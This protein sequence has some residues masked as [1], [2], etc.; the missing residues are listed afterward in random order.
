M[1]K[2][3]GLRTTNNESLRESAKAPVQTES[4]ATLL[5]SM[6]FPVGVGN[7]VGKMVYMNKTAP[8]FCDAVHCLHEQ[9]EWSANDE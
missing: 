1:N 6:P 8:A 5:D 4:Y 2:H 3:N 9:A 7:F